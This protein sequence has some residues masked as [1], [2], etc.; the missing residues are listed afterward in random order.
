MRRT[1]PRVPRVPRLERLSRGTKYVSKL[2]TK[3]VKVNMKIYNKKKT[4]ARSAGKG[5]TKRLEKRY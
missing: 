2:H 3:N 1:K 4:L 5:N